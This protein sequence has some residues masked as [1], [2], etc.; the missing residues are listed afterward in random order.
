MPK[1]HPG[2]GTPRRKS[3]HKTKSTAQTASTAAAT[4]S[5]APVAQASGSRNASSKIPTPRPIPNGVLL[6]Q[7]YRLAGAVAEQRRLLAIAEANYQR[8]LGR[9]SEHLRLDPTWAWEFQT[10][11]MIPSD[12]RT[13]SSSGM[14]MTAG[15]GNS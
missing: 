1:G 3:H 12:L 11:F 7:T 2:T 14:S 15:S 10:G 5:T 13:S 8:H 4:E 9:I 6:E